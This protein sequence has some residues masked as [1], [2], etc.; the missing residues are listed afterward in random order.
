MTEAGV[1]WDVSQNRS[2]LSMFVLSSSSAWYLVVVGDAVNGGKVA[3]LT[4]LIRLYCYS[5]WREVEGQ[6]ALGGFVIVGWSAE[7]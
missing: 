3:T 7:C 5:V 1:V 4:L 2:V 6:G